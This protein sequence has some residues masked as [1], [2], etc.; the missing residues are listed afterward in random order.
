MFWPNNKKTLVKFSDIKISGKNT[1]IANAVNI[2]GY[3][4][5]ILFRFK[6]LEITPRIPKFIY[7]TKWLWNDEKT[8]KLNEIK[9]L[10]QY[11]N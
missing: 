10:K 11:D 3:Y 1:G 6:P 5:R 9:Y 2:D 4:E 8:R 7:T